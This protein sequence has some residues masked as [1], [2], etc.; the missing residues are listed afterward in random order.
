VEHALLFLKAPSN[1][2][3]KVRELTI[4]LYRDWNLLS[5]RALPVMIPLCFVA[6]HSVA[7][8]PAQIRDAIRRAAGKRAPFFRSGS[9]LES[10]GYLYW[11]LEPRAELE[12]LKESC[13]QVFSA[14]DA[15]SGG[16]T[17]TPPR[18]RLNAPTDADADRRK[19]SLFPTARGFY[20][21]SLE[22][23][24]QSAPPSLAVPEP[25][26]FPA[27]AAVLLRLRSLS[28]ERQAGEQ[29]GPLPA[30]QPWWQSLFW[31]EVGR[32]PL[33]KS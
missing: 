1:I 20:L 14:S 7:S 19:R 18:A 32:V 10:G 4:C 23:R 13:G 3:K 22:G 6:L 2:E 30:K 16:G 5:A 8:T 27:K 24:M 29:A 12:R 11:D 31:E 33:R 28:E 26:S 25:L 9:I 17:H 15:A 21:C